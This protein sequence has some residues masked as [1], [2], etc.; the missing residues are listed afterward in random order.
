MLTLGWGPPGCAPCSATLSEAQGYAQEGADQGVHSGS[1]TLLLACPQTGPKPTLGRFSASLILPPRSSV[2]SLSLPNILAPPLCAGSQ[3]MLWRPQKVYEVHGMLFLRKT[4]Q[5]CVGALLR[6]AIL[7]A[8][9]TRPCVCGR[10]RARGPRGPAR[11]ARNCSCRATG[12]PARHQQ[13]L[14]PAGL[15]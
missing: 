3:G 14:Q 2:F 11:P 8:S 4:L 6:Q 1:F 12:R 7:M 15:H 13:L 9:L 10:W 5:P